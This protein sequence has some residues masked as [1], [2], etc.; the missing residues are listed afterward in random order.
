M[1]KQVKQTRQ[2]DDI[3]ILVQTIDDNANPL[4]SDFTPSVLKLSEMGI[5]GAK[6]VL[7]LL[8]APRYETRL[9]AERVLEGVV[10]GRNGWEY[11]QG[12]T[13]DDGQQ[14]T[15]DLLKANGSYRADAPPKERRESIEKWR[16]WLEAEERTDQHK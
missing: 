6:A 1:P 7:D 2:N 8:D 15:N 4:H 9:R 16:Q 14:K 13:D 10:M 5:P 12:Y 3:K 11:G